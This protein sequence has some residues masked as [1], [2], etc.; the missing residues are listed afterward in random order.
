MAISKSDRFYPNVKYKDPN[1]MT[2]SSLWLFLIVASFWLTS[3]TNDLGKCELFVTY[4]FREFLGEILS[5]NLAICI[6]DQ[7][8]GWKPT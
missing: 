2:I 8:A 4:D 3:L 6:K 1:K 7:M 5:D